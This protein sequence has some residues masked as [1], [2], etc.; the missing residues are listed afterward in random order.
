[1][2]DSPIPSIPFPL[3]KGRGSNFL[4]RVRLKGVRFGGDSDI[5]YLSSELKEGR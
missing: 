4:D 2:F 3:I 5:M 1:M